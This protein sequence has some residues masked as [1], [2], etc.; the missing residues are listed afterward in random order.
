[1]VKNSESIG[2][3]AR[4]TAMSVMLVTIVSCASSPYDRENLPAAITPEVQTAEW[5]QE[6]WMPQC[7][8]GDDR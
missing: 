2:A 6:W 8:F 5:A 4:Y 7:R 1:M 3:L